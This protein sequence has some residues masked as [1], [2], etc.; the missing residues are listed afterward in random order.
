MLLLPPL[1]IS[2]LPDALWSVGV[3]VVVGAGSALLATWRSSAVYAEKFSNQGREVSQLKK[4][5]ENVLESIKKD[6]DHIRTNCS[7]ESSKQRLTSLEV[8]MKNV[9]QL[10]RDLLKHRETDVKEL[11]RLISEIQQWMSRLETMVEYALDDKKK[12]D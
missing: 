4:D 8:Q 12:K 3:A 5:L 11:N 9:E 1:A 7:T 6:V 2:T 10:S